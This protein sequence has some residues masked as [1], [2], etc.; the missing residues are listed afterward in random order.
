M[1]DR[2]NTENWE[3]EEKRVGA[4]DSWEK[5][6]LA[7]LE[8]SLKFQDF[9]KWKAEMHAVGWALLAPLSLISAIWLEWCYNTG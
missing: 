5:E 4:T 2:W 7:L 6:I 3:I 8:T 9:V 1:R